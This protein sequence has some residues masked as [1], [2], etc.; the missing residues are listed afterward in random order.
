MNNYYKFNK[1]RTKVFLA[2]IPLV[3]FWV[4]IANGNTI[5]NSLITGAVSVFATF[6]WFIY[7]GR[8]ST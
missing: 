2:V 1:K 4:W 5:Y 7:A 8:N 6:C 3:L